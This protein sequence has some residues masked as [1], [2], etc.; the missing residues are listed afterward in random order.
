MVTSKEIGAEDVDFYST[1]LQDWFR[2]SGNL[3]PVG[4]DKFSRTKK[5]S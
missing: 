4:S 1:Q 3:K 5:R 2:Y